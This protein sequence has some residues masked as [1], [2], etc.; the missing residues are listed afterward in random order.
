LKC[1]S[2]LL[3]DM[4]TGKCGKQQLHIGLAVG[5]SEQQWVA[6]SSSCALG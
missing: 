4:A 2:N 1:K 6:V 3:V 5:S